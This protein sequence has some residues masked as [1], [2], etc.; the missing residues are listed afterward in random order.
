MRKRLV[1][2]AALYL[3]GLLCL[4]G[5]AR[6]PA[7]SAAD[8]AE[9]SDAP[10]P[11]SSAPLSDEEIQGLYAQ[12]ITGLEPEVELDVSGREWRYGAENDLKN[13]YY[14]LLSERP[15]LKYAYDMSA[16]ISEEGTAS[17]TFSYMPYKTGAYA[18]GAPAGSSTIGSLHDADVM[19]QSMID[20]RESLPVA[21]SEPSLEVEALQRAL[22]QA[23]Y[24]YISFTLSR[25]GTAI[26]ATPANGMTLADCAGRISESFGVA[27]AILG[28]TVTEDMSDREKVEAAYSY[29]T[30]NVEYDERY[31]SDRDTLPLESTTALGALRDGQAICG[32]YSHALE[33]LL[34]MCN[35][36]N[37][38]VS[39]SAQGEYHAWNYVILDGEGFYCDPT[40][41]RGGESRHFLLTADELR[42]L[43]GYEWDDVL[44]ASLRR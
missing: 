19:A 7:K 5:C 35:I 20:G 6:N 36:E 2:A 10:A 39:G 28:E 26:Q 8:G 30:R 18:A 37:Y 34:D 42:S 33:T 23:G 22:G 40:A 11:T 1:L 41:D 43:G 16:E 4:A 44:Y 25:D 3:V 32:G 21:I 17:C 29:I 27:G 14:S 31:F 24:G 9:A 38:T 15:E 13:L 12:A